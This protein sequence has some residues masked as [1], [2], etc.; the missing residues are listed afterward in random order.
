MFKKQFKKP[1]S[2]NVLNIFENTEQKF[3]VGLITDCCFSKLN[4]GEKIDLILDILRCLDVLKQPFWL[5][6]V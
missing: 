6:L 2:E 4:R 1:F 5:L 3:S